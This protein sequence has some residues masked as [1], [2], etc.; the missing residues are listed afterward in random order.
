MNALEEKNTQQQLSVNLTIAIPSDRILILKTELQELKQQQLKGVYW[1]MKNLE[2]RINRK[3]EWIKDHLL[4]PQQFKAVL[5]VENGG[6]VFYPK[7]RGQ[8]WSFHA[9]K[10]TE[11]LDQNFHR[12][13]SQKD[14]I[15]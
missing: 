8:T 15:A 5:D 2:T 4:Y 12:I 10:M 3:S 13:F 7:S 6:F 1:S 14:K 11:F 9:L